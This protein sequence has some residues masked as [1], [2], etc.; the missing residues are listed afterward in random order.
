[1]RLQRGRAGNT[2]RP[3]TPTLRAAEWQKRGARL[4]RGPR[5]EFG[6]VITLLQIGINPAASRGLH[7]LRDALFDRLREERR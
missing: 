1:M 6:L 3:R 2:I 7:S 5:G 4:D